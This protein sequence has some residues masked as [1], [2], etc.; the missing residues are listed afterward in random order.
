M[1][2]RSFGIIGA[3]AA[4]AAVALPT[5]HAQSRTG[6]QTVRAMASH[7]KASNS[8][9]F[10]LK[11]T[12]SSGISMTMT[13]ELSVGRATQF[14]WDLPAVVTTQLNGFS[15]QVS[16]MSYTFSVAP[17][18]SQDLVI[19]GAP[20]H[21]VTWNN[22]PANTVIQ[23]TEHVQAQITSALG[24]FS[25]SAAYPVSTVT[26]DAA[27]YL[28]VTPDTTLPAAAQTIATS[29]ASGKTSE[30]AVVE[31]VVNWVASH[32]H[33]S[34]TQN[35]TAATV[36]ATHTGTC[37]G[38]TNLDLAMLRFLGI[39]AQAAMGWVSAQPITMTNSHGKQTI[40]W[41]VPG[42]P[43][44]FHAWM[45][46]YFPDGGWVSF[47]PQLEKFFIDPRHIAFMVSKDATNITMGNWAASYANGNSPTGPTLSNGDVEIIPTQGGQVTL[48]T[49]DSFKTMIGLVTGDV[50]HM[51][52]FSR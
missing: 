29:L 2:G 37:E 9:T 44:E 10:H 24:S 6:A 46:V 40:Q 47:D 52:L 42:T 33:Y 1:V 11:G 4:L 27:T 36:Y 22:P 7:V 20:I 16:Q 31:A 28:P 51:L 39:P 13:G 50:N 48:T 21:R 49:T 30:Q 5:A 17:D 19:N 18:A 15:Q 26:G 41:S 25:S 32:T 14:T 43:G 34:L 38:Y 45:N 23:V 12:M 8:G 3:A 35:N